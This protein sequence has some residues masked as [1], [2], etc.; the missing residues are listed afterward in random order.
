M[1][2]MSE[3]LRV[4]I[5]EDSEDDAL[6]L[7]R[8]LRQA[9]YDTLFRRVQSEPDMVAA[10]DAQ[11]WDIVLSDH[12][13]PA[14]S[15]QRALKLVRNRGLDTP[16]IIVSGMIGEAAAV[17]AMRAGAQD[18]IMKG[19]FAR[20]A[21]A[22]ERELRD[23]QAR[24]ERVLAEKALMAQTEELRIARDIQENLSPSEM[25]RIDGYDI[26]GL[27]RPAEATGGDYF[28]FFPIRD[29]SL[30]LVVGDVTGHGIGPAL[31]MS[32]VRACLRALAQT[33][34][35][36][37]E[38]IRHANRLL[39]ADLGEDR[40]ITLIVA[41]LN[42]REHRLEYLNVGHP[43]AYVL[44][45]DGV[46]KAHLTSEVPAIGLNREGAFPAVGVAQ[47]APGEIVLFLTDGVLESSSPA[48]EDFGVERVLQVVRDHA[49][50]TATQ[51]VGAV[52]NAVRQFSAPASQQDDI[53][54]VVM[55]VLCF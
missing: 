42:A 26:A 32:D 41:S 20:L 4:L 5:V 31:L 54:V 8:V 45:A 37:G 15:S 28:D 38:I 39:E 49:A 55:K 22:I 30:G 51:I 53:T 25:P 16:F 7:V 21:P 46:V 19:Q 14:F 29:G 1:L 23:A 17:E 2:G 33:C 48:G 6:L 27:S 35:G 9:G 3:R 13:M 24:R 47:L 50:E 11:G 44:G 36:I 34:N 52:A 43:A 10:L 12:N 40:F 18:Y